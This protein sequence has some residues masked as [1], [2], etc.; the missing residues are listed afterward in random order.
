MENQIIKP[1]IYTLC[2]VIVMIAGYFFG[3]ISV[4]APDYVVATTRMTIA[5]DGV[6]ALDNIQKDYAI[7]DADDVGLEALEERGLTSN[8]QEINP[9]TNSVAGNGKI[10]DISNNK[11]SGNKKVHKISVNSAQQQRTRKLS[12]DPRITIIDHSTATEYD[13]SI[14]KVEIQIPGYEDQ[15]LINSKN[16][17]NDLSL[18]KKKGNKDQAKQKPSLAD[19]YSPRKPLPKAPISG[20]TKKSANGKLLPYSP[21]RG[22]PLW[23]AYGNL[24]NIDKSKRPIAF[25]MGGLGTDIALTMEAIKTLPSEVTL[26]FVPYTKDLQQMINLARAYGHEVILEIP[27]ESH[28]FPRKDVGSLALEVK[29]TEKQYKYKIASL[30]SSTTGYSGVMNYLGSKYF[31]NDQKTG[32]FLSDIKDYGLYFVE[33]K[34][35]R[36]G[37]LSSIAQVI[38]IPYAASINIVDEVLSPS[39]IKQ[40]Y[41]IIEKNTLIGTPTICTSYLSRI[42]LTALRTRLLV[43]NNDKGKNIQLIP[44]SAYIK[45]ENM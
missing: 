13:A 24:T 21:K 29:D 40:N 2:F 5:I 16:I 11:S 20:Y 22:A 33:N 6:P 19:P 12:Q 41:D 23:R 14:D 18:N 39:M 7:E 26:G 38:D 10:I 34:T 30:L 8:Y 28:D 45:Y 32:Q 35:V 17:I 9:F 43:Y 44:I 25:I 4:P 42:S 36:A 37:L 1:A 3:L 15:S 31:L 27:M